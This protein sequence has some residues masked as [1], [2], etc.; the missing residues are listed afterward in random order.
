ML[1][2]NAYE[3]NTRVPHKLLFP[4][5]FVESP[6][7]KFMTLLKWGC[8]REKRNLLLFMPIYIQ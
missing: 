1:P 8:L 3:G 5:L 2:T 7:K 4:F 6:T